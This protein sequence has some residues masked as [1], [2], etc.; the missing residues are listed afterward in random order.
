MRLLY[1]DED[2]GFSVTD[3]LNGDCIFPY[4]ILSHTWGED[5]DEVTFDD[6][7]KGIGKDKP[8]Y[9]KIL[10]CG[11][12]ARQD[13]LQ[14][15]WIDT[16]CIDKGNHAERSRE[17]NAMFR[18]YR[19]AKRCYV[20]LSDVPYSPPG[21]GY[22]QT[23]QLWK[24]AF[25]RSRWFSRGWTLQ[26]L[27]APTSV[28]FFSSKHEQNLEYRRLGD[29]SSLTQWI[30]EITGI[31]HSAL[32]GSR[33]S[34]F[35]VEERFMWS[36][37]RDTKKPE[38]K[39]YSLLGLFDVEMPL[40]YGEG[41][42]QAYN[43]LR[44]V[45]DRRKRC[46]Q[47]LRISDP[48]DDKKSIEKTDGGLLKDSYR[49]IL[50]TSDYQRWHSAHH[51]PLLWI[52]GDPGKGKTMLLCGIIDDLSISVSET[53]LLSYFFCQATDSRNNNATAVLR[54]LIYLL[55]NQRPS[56]TS[57][58][59]Q[60]YEQADKSLFT[61]ANAWIV[62]C[63]ILINMLQDPSLNTVYLVIDAL[64]ECAIDRPRL[65]RFIAQQSTVTSRIK[66][67]VSSRN[68]PD[69]EEL[70]DEIEEKVEICLELNAESVSTAVGI[71]IQYKILQL[72][73][74]K[75][76]DDHIRKAVLQHLVSNANDTFL[77]VAL[78]CQNLH[79]TPRWRTLETLNEFPIGLGSLYQRMIEQVCSSK[80]ADLC[81]QILA[82]TAIVYRPITLGELS[83]L[84][85]RLEDISDDSESL[86][87][88][89]GHCGSFLII[90]EGVVYFVHKSARDY[91]LASAVD[92]LFPSGLGAA[93]HDI[94][95]RS[96]QILSKVLCRDMYSL[97]ALGYPIEKVTKPEPDPLAASRYSCIHWV[98][99]LLDWHSYAD[100]QLEIDLPDKAAVED[101]MRT[102]YLYWL[103]AL[104]LNMSM[105]EGVLSMAKL[106]GLLHVILAYPG[107]CTD[108]Y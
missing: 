99:H 42:A 100:T 65:L 97:C 73:K 55:I 61:D 72:A 10:F 45:I 52:K 46:M 25:R 28:E 93:H 13:K 12:Q 98:N 44:E 88:I 8:G 95:L 43:R 30:H 17:I 32:E 85:Q 9:K 49:W 75:N 82:L 26:E 107:Y 103:E 69:I 56:L 29:K 84:I 35:S 91:L 38:D 62:L 106:E 92:K 96:L 33:M 108:I 36:E 50:E 6:M 77:W 16:C 41:V 39:I 58:V 53:V 54:G 70:L 22:D 60:K 14:Y 79:S 67:I 2:G 19:D 81:K 3:D 4:A 102:R 37:R 59:L 5:D 63:E 66:W 71:Y 86:R 89:I 51:S 7:M 27:L 57:H 15:F 34:Q 40:F 20:Y 90:R 18:R 11:E 105:S 48:R 104:S 76:Y 64:D 94:S 83:S 21:A 80:E 31:P 68:G 24:S 47:D 74:L 101:F 78:V 1:R 87:E 23:G